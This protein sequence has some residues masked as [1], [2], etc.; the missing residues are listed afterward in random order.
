[1][2]AHQQSQQSKGAA[3]FVH[4]H[5]TFP[6]TT[7]G[8]TSWAS[9]TTTTAAERLPS[10]GGFRSRF[11]GTR[12]WGF[13]F[14]AG[15]SIVFPATLC[16]QS[17][18]LL[19]RQLLTT[20]NREARSL[21][22]FPGCHCRSVTGIRVPWYNGGMTLRSRPL[23]HTL[24]GIK[25]R[26]YNVNHAAYSRYG[27]KGVKVYAPW[28]ALRGKGFLAFESWVLDNLGVKREGYSLDR[29]DGDGNY[30]PGNLRWATSRE[31]SLNRKKGWTKN[32]N[33]VRREG[34]RWVARFTLDN[35]EYYV[36]MFKTKEEAQAAS[37]AKRS[38]LL[39]R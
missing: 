29:I 30:E 10:L 9:P 5:L 38:E 20:A 19:D 28:L 32:R 26:C 7:G 16:S 24:R 27:G 36:G 1:M 6:T 34:N 33:W 37:E 39:L 3:L 13:Q 11:N 8:L 17:A 4:S 12:H 15:S 2:G 14:A 18:A 25:E 22:A 23:Y 31:Q 35:K 21:L